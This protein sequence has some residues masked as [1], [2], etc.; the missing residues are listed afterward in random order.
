VAADFPDGIALVIGGSGGL[1]RAVCVRLAQAGA[2]V[3]LTY[4][5][6]RAAADETLRALGAA[7]SEA[8][9]IDLGDAADVERVIGDVAGRLGPLHTV[10]HAAGSDIAMRWVSQVSPT[11]WH[12]VM[13]ADADGFFHVV[14][15]ALPELRKARGAIVALTSAGLARYPSRD[16]LSVAPKAAI[17]ALVRGVAREEGRFGVRANSVAV[18]VVDAGMFRRLTAQAELSQEWREAARRNTPLGR[19]GTAEEVAE[20]AV[21]LASARASFVTGQQL[22]VDGGYS[23]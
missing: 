10:V 6:N 12:E 3:A 20:A 18:G 5:K 19:E 21:F 16:I 14:R 1:G 17:E 15:A 22:V 13:R 8:V 2:R 11:E 7:G 9:A 23:V 4:R